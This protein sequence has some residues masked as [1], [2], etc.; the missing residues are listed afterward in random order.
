MSDVLIKV[1]GEGGF[2]F[3]GFLRESG[4]YL[5]LLDD[6]VEIKT[7]MQS[8]GYE[9]R[10]VGQN[11]GGEI[12][13]TFA[14]DLDPD[15]LE[16]ILEA[17]NFA[18][19]AEFEYWSWRHGG[20]L[21]R[22]LFK[23]KKEGIPAI[24]TAR[25]IGNDEFTVTLTQEGKAVNVAATVVS[26]F[27]SAFVDKSGTWA[28][29]TNGYADDGAY[30]TNAGV[31]NSNQVLYYSGFG[32]EIPET[33][34][35]NYVEIEMQ[36]KVST[37]ASHIKTAFISAYKNTERGVLWSSENEPL[38]DLVVTSRQCGTWTPAQ[39]N[40][41][42]CQIKIGY[43]RMASTA[44]TLSGDYVKMTVSYTEVG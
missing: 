5:P 33:A 37:A 22:A 10:T 35:I 40:S 23:V 2:D 1:A 26:A 19:T 28:G 30:F 18:D 42:D 43:K 8:S 32:F 9:K 25:G 17:L 44:C 36:Y 39:L 15:D 16:D 7:K 3:T 34:K 11:Q 4:G 38:T 31:L 12:V 21:R 24:T 20:A 29:E 14:A 6:Q 41:S 13:L 27:P